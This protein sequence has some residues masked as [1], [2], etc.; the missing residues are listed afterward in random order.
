YQVAVARGSYLPEVSLDAYG[1]LSRRNYSPYAEATDWSAEVDFTWAVFDGG[2]IRSDLLTARSRLEQAILNR[3]ELARQVDLE[4]RQAYL[5]LQSDSAELLT[6]QT[7][8]TSADE[9]FR[10]VQEE[11]RGGLATNLEVFA[12][13]NQL[14]SA[15]LDLE[16]QKYQVR[17]DEVALQLVQGLIPLDAGPAPAEAAPETTS[18]GGGLAP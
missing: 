1:Y 5:T 9:N 17:L 14:L 18:L 12:A 3:D 15:R 6:L 10:L 8:V 11:Y 13:Q 4:V 2:R 7:S 16:R